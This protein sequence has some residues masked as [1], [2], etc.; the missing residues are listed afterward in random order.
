MALIK[1][2][3][4]GQEVSLSEE[5]CPNCGCPMKED[6]TPSKNI[7]SEVSNNANNPA[8]QTPPK[9]GTGKVL[10]FVLVGIALVAGTVFVTKSLSSEKSEVK[11]R[12]KDPY[13]EK[14]WNFLLTRLKC[15]STASLNG[16]VSPDEEPTRYLAKELGKSGAKIAAYTVDAE[17]GF[18]A[19]MRSVFFVCFINGEPCAALPEKDF[20]IPRLELELAML[21]INNNLS[22]K[23]QTTDSP[24]EGITKKDIAGVWE[25]TSETWFLDDSGEKK[26]FTPDTDRPWYFIYYENGTYVLRVSGNPDVEFE[27]ELYEDGRMV[28]EGGPKRK[29]LSF[30]G[31][32]MEIGTYRDGEIRACNVLKRVE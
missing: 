23:N 25:L 21:D 19:M 27:Y 9:S 20:N 30:S 15:P 4:C 22:E 29:I 8:P 3:E 10:L 12:K 13:M 24:S 7:Q 2:P 17:N 26:Y 6:V 1:C 18:G 31:N 14:G 5:V 16:Y 11:L 32:R 28:E